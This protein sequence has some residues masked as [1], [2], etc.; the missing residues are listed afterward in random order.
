M[1]ASLDLEVVLATT[2]RS[3]FGEILLRNAKVIRYL[4][5]LMLGQ[6]HFNLLLLEFESGAQWNNLA[7][8]ITNIYFNR[9]ISCHNKR[10]KKQ[11]AIVLRD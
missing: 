9:S 8:T 4:F 3:F 7:L 2:A 6:T 1:C 11:V 10:L 5:I